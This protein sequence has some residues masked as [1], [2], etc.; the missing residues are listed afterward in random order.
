MDPRNNYKI[1]QLNVCGMSDNCYLALNM[2]LRSQ[3]I[4]VVCL[5][6]TKTSNIQASTFPGMTIILKPNIVNPRQRGVALLVR[7]N[8][9]V[10]RHV[11]MEPP[12]LD[13]LVCTIALKN[14]QAL[15]SVLAP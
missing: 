1:M 5:S 12:S 6:E 9:Q 3:N 4:D 7:E 2:Y 15:F 14:G 11:D 13:V 10:T 8:L